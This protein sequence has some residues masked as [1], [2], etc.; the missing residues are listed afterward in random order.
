V[1]K[2]RSAEPP[3]PTK[4]AIDFQWL[5][6][7][8]LI[9]NAWNP[10][11]EDD[12]TFNL[13]KDEIA[14]VGFVDPI[15]VVA[16]D[17]GTY[18]IL[19]GEHRWRAASDLGHEEVP[20]VLLT[21]TKFKE[22]D[23]QKFVTVR[24][25][26]IHGKLD[27]EKFLALYK[28]MASKYGEEPMQRLLGYSD[29]KA[30]QRMLGWVKK[31][32]KESLPKEMAGDVDKAMKETKTMA[33]LGNV[34]QDLFQKY[35]ETCSQSFLVFDYGKQRHVYIA[36]DAKMRRSL[37]RF[38]ESCRILGCDINEAMRPVIDEF[39]KKAAIE[40]ERKMQ[41]EAVGGSSTSSVAGKG[42]WE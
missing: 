14:E 6:I 31:G 40:V 36:C 33:D 38:L 17:D 1:P 7:D 42:E 9:P 34:I 8:K 24:W 37:D 21:D 25:N 10:N 19:G 13:L 22:T 2:K 26:A 41:D 20:C 29:S 18:L 15:Q 16:L 11:K 3:T 35:G 32:I 39:T 28:E 30:F 5:P 23:L 27:P 12:L 4:R